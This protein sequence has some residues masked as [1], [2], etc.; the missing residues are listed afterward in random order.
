MT[1]AGRPALDATELRAVELVARGYTDA[2]I[3]R[4]L[5][6]ATRMVKELLSQVGTKLGTRDRA[7]IV[8]AAILAGLLRV[9]VRHAV[10]DGFSA[11]QFEVLVRIARGM[12]NAQ[13]AAELGVSLQAVKSRVCRLL[14]LLGACSREEAVVAGVACGALPLVPVRARERVAA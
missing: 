5:F 9:P 7:G 3:G 14:A 12:S 10:P 8:G 11:G 4:E 6:M 2:A 1:R 13:I